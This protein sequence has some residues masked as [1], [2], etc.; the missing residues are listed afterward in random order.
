MDLFT[1]MEDD[2][3][4]LA[5]E[6][7]KENPF[8]HYLDYLKELGEL[9]AQ[10]QALYDGVGREFINLIETTNMSKVYKMPVLMAFYN[11]GNVRC[12]VTE[13]QLLEA[14]KDFFGKGTNWRD[15]DKNMTYEKYL[16]ISDREHI[17]KILQMP[18][19]FLQES[20]KGYFVQRA[21]Y[22]LAL[23]DELREIVQ[24][25]CFIMHMKDAIEY[26]AM[27]YYKRR[28]DNNKES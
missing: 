18:V 4:R 17:K 8:K 2:V 13:E 23:C 14:W 1:Y 22:A 9:T 10:E 26:R 19:H 21:G 7:S 11:Q 15:F 12:E 3:Y 5:I 16:E 27:D 20:G 24:D 6:H 28:Y 25:P